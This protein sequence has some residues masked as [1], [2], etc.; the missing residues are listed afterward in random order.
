MGR[1]TVGIH[2]ISVVI[3]KDVRP[4]RSLKITG[5]GGGGCGV[6][7]VA[8]AATLG[9]GGAAAVGMRAWAAARAAAQ[10][11]ATRITAGAVIS[12]TAA[13]TAALPT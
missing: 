1:V 7:V 5:R 13:T 12:A 4:Q 2:S 11:A 8:T 10:A 6:R 3:W 9:R